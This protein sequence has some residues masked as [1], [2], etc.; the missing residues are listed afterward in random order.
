M[1]QRVLHKSLNRVRT[2]DTKEYSREAYERK[3]K[4]D[5]FNRLM[6]EGCS[7][8]VALEV[9]K[10]SRASYYRWLKNYRDYGL[11][12]LENESRRPKKIRRQTWSKEIEDRVR[13]LRLEFK[14]WGKYKIAVMYKRFYN[15]WLSPSTIG[16]ILRKL[17][18][19]GFI[20]PVSFYTGDY[21]PKPRVF[22]GHAQR[23]PDNKKSEI[24]GDLIQIDHTTATLYNGTLVKHFKAVC[25]ITKYTAERVYRSAT[26]HN[27]ADFLS[28]V[29]QTFP[30]PIRSIQVDGG[31]EFMAEFESTCEKEAFPLYVLPP[32]APEQNGCVERGNR[33]VK[34][35]FYSQYDGL[36]TLDVL[37]NALRKFSDF[38]NCVRPHQALQYLTPSEYYAYNFGA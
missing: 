10:I 2:V 22:E 13:K 34:A 26:A 38:Y 33:T 37:N 8:E 16:R 4:L 28:L 12:G 7:Q 19:R 30:F 3:E 9:L 15:A 11:T 23:L 6:E 29:K 20:K 14:F 27:A 32:R 18:H 5:N 21:T 35:E 36:T 1:Q 17:I 25:P 24:A 31:S